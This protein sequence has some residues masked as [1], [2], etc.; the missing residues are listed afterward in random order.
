MPDVQPNGKTNITRDTLVPLGLAGGILLM[1]ITG[2]LRAGALEERL[3][4][5]KNRV[6]KIEL[7]QESVNTLLREQSNRLIRIET[8]VESI[9]RAIQRLENQRPLPQ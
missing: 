1:A 5:T 8:Q 4:T 2:A 9:G 7:V 6:D 3:G